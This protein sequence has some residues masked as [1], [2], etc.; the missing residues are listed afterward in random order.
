M[1]TQSI[2]QSVSPVA[3]ATAT[4]AE[5]TFYSHIEMHYS[6]CVNKLSSL[7]INLAPES[8]FGL[9]YLG[10]YDTEIAEMDMLN[11]V[12]THETFVQAQ[13]REVVRKEQIATLMFLGT[14][15]KEALALVDQLVSLVPSQVIAA[16]Q[17]LDFHNQHIELVELQRQSTFSKLVRGG[18]NFNE[19]V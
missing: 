9:D 6:V 11:L 13:K 8:T 1:Y 16:T 2:T 18:M 5:Q 15:E 19:T 4:Q 12:K 3:T 10:F 14:T 7:G 17:S